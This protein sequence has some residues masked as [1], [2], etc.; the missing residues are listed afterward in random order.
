M[1]GKKSAGLAAIAFGIAM[2][3][4][5][6]ATVITFDEYTNSP[7]TNHYASLWHRFGRVSRQ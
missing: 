2:A 1:L 6:H 3:G 7:R 4:M 5:A